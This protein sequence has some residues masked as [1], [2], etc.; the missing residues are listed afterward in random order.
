MVEYVSRYLYKICTN[1]KYLLD[2]INMDICR[3]LKSDS[4]YNNSSLLMGGPICFLSILLRLNIFD[5]LSKDLFS[6]W[7]L[8]TVVYNL[9]IVYIV[10]TNFRNTFFISEMETVKIT[11]N[12]HIHV[13]KQSRIYLYISISVC[14]DF[15]DFIKIYTV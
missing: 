14:A 9:H 12:S 5:I 11:V 1:K 13:L 6:S 2:I 8:S 15:K 10:N 3:I 4:L 7:H